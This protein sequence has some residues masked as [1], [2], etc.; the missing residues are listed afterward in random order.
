MLLFCKWMAICY[1]DEHLDNEN[2]HTSNPDFNSKDYMSVLNR[3]DGKWYVDR[4]KE[5][6]S[7]VWENYVKNGS[8]KSHEEYLKNF[9]K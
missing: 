3:E 8:V 5:F 9:H 2:R 1:A 7:E 4:L 6:E